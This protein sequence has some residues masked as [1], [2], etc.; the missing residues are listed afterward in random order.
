MGDGIRIKYRPNGPAM[1]QNGSYHEYKH[2]FV[3]AIWPNLGNN[4]I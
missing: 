1:Y 3:I 4:K 2:A